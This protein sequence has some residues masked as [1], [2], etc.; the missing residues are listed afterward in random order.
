MNALLP[1]LLATLALSACTTAPKPATAPP[2]PTKRSAQVRQTTLQPSD[3][4]R[5]RTGEF[6]KTYHVGRSVKGR[7]GRTMHEAHRVYRLEKPSRWNLL[8]HQPPLASTGPVN[9]VVD[10]AFKPAP[11]SSEIRAEHNRQRAISKE[12]EQAR[13]RLSAAA[14][15]A[16]AQL[17]DR[18]NSG[19]EI[20]GLR[21][22]IVV[23]KEENA[24]LK[25]QVPGEP[26]NE[27]NQPS[28]A[29]SL[30]QWEAKL[31][32]DDSRR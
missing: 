3:V 8:R 23:L 10:S 16:E 15:R 19:R 2:L 17:V 1:F 7:Q 13:E 11:E 26:D 31:E 32:D 4:R 28:P 29:E 27:T 21:Q 30:R 6:V 22:E 25:A 5:V 18:Q 20:A 12:F 9:Q 24:A 14:A